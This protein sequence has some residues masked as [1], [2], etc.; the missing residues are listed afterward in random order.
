LPWFNALSS[1]PRPATQMMRRIEK[2][3]TGLR[4]AQGSATDN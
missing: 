3:G 2:S 4:F 1:T